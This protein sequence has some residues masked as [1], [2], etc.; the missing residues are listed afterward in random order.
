VFPRISQIGI[1]Y[2]NGSLSD[3]S[4]ENG[5]E[6][7]AGDRLP[8]FLVDGE[9]IFD[10]LREP[11]FHLLTFVDGQTEQKTDGI[12]DSFDSMVDRHS[13]PLYPHVAELFGVE[14]SFS[15]LLRP[16]NYIAMISQESS[17]API[18]NYLK[19]CL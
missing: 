14:K 13:V 8:Y 3:H 15:V 12:S 16:D 19:R 17:L 4:G 10:R 1:N 11:R 5:F 7:R 6:V 2:R 9:S 18:E